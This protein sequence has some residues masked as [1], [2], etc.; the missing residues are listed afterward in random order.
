M[1]AGIEKPGNRY[2]ASSTGEQKAML[3]H[4]TQQAIAHLMGR[5]VRWVRD[6]VTVGRDDVTG[7]Y[8]GP[9]VMAWHQQ[10]GIEA[11]R[12]QQASAESETTKSAK[13]RWE[14]SRAEKSEIETQIL[15]KNYGPIELMTNGLMALASAVRLEVEALPRSMENDFPEEHRSRL[16][17]ELKNQCRQILRRLA[18]RGENLTNDSR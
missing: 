13:E 10:F 18:N 17:Q 4:M 6:H 9:V 15:K 12:K 5:S 1:S 3:G 8:D 7:L 14:L 11:D 16:A 2:T